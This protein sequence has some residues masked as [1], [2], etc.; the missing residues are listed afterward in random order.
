[1]GSAFAAIFLVVS[2]LIYS[3]ISSNQASLEA[4]K[5][6]SH[7][8]EVTSLLDKNLFLLDE[9]ETGQR[10]FLITGGR[11]KYLEP[12]N[13]ALPLI[14][15]NLDA[16]L[17]LVQ[18]NPLQVMRITEIK[19]MTQQKLAELAQTIELK[20][21]GKSAES[22]NLVLTGQGK[23]IMDKIRIEQDGVL[24]AEKDLLVKRN[25]TYL[26]EQAAGKFYA[27][28][29]GTI[30]ALLLITMYFLINRMAIRPMSAM[31]KALKA[32]LIDIE[33]QVKKQEKSLSQQALAIIET[34]ST[35]QELSASAMKSEDQAKTVI[36]LANLSQEAAFKELA[37]SQENLGGANALSV[38]MKGVSESIAALAA[39]IEGVKSI[40]NTVIEISKET[41]ILA[42]NAS[43][44]SSRAGAFGKGFGEI[45]KQIRALAQQSKLSVERAVDIMAGVDKH[46]RTMIMM[47]DSVIKDV[48]KVAANAQESADSLNALTETSKN[49]NIS[50]RAIILN[51]N[52]QAKALEQIDIAMRNLTAG[53]KEIVESANFTRV[54]LEKLNTGITLIE[55]TI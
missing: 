23:A 9:A 36:Q 19:G 33:A 7:T 12:Y 34:S 31:V 42:L 29:G 38:T 43:I 17:V 47:S 21:T 2:F 13:K 28:I 18:D 40:A 11:E 32:P 41:K 48:N 55:K 44:E 1:M 16:L 45:A 26:K 37:R 46:T 35:V 54:S 53:T 3:Q 4:G 49:S 30:A 20:K 50:V 22:L 52:E 51:A 27:Y 15:Q 24:Q 6:V 5:W 8:N 14:S 10:G 25:Q 39:Q